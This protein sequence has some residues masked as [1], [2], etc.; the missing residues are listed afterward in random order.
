MKLKTRELVLAALLAAL[1]V[2]CFV[3]LKKTRLYADAVG[4]LRE[5]RP[6]AFF[7]GLH[8]AVWLFAALTLSL[9]AMYLI[10]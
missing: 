7:A 5:V 3:R 4:L 6:D 8:P 10:L 2:F 1:F 9:G